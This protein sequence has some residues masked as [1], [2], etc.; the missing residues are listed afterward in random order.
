MQF[1]IVILTFMVIYMSKYYKTKMKPRFNLRIKTKIKHQT[2]LY[3]DTQFRKEQYLAEAVKWCEEHACRGYKAVNEGGF[4]LDPR[5]INRILDGATIGR[6]KEHLAILTKEEEDL[7]V[8][9]AKNKNR[10]LQ[11]VTK[12]DLTKVIINVLKYRV[13]CKNHRNY[14]KLTPN[15]YSS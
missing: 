6:N 14:K 4:H 3:R 9:Y 15:A 2:L 12:K 8:R 5:T 1:E 7:V 11:G 13:H 10:S